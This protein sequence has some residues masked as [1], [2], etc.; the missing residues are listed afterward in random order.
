[1]RRTAYELQRWTLTG[2]LVRTWVRDADWFAPYE[3]RRPIS[4]DRDPENWVTA[5]HALDSARVLVFVQVPQEGWRE[6][7]GPP[8]TAP[9]GL[10]MYPDWDVANVFD[11]RI[12]LVDVQHGRVIT[13]ITH[14]STLYAFSDRQYVLSYRQNE[15]GTPFV[16]VWRLQMTPR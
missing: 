12:E 16:D 5:I 15:A 13:T 11:T 4:P 2:E 14:P 3:E 9:S 1:M 7:L 8:R 10:V 6:H